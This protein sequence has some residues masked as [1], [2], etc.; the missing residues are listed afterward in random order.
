MCVN[1]ANSYFGGTYFEMSDV[2]DHT[3]GLI[4][5]EVVSFKVG[6]CLRENFIKRG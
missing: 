4:V 1:G 5:K 3:P 6:D 2:L